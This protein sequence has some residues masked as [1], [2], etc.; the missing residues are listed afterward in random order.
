M[1]GKVN[2]VSR[3]TSPP[4]LI[5]RLRRLD[6]CTVSDACDVLGISGVVASV[7]PIWEGARVCG[8]VVTMQLRAV[9]PDSPPTSKV[10]LGVRAIDQCSAGDVIVV[11]N[12]ARV[13]MGGWGG[14][15]SLAA[16]SCGVGGVVI[17]GACRDVDE[18]RELHFPVFAMASVPRT[19][20]GRVYEESCGEAVNFAGIRVNTGDVVIAD[21]SGVVFIPEVALP[22]LLEEAEL[23]KER[24]EGMAAMLRDG[25]LPRDVLSGRYEQLLDD[26]KRARGGRGV[27]AGPGKVAPGV[28]KR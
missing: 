26:L 16:I 9:D 22:A 27:N 5:E 6:V 11:A 14:L 28:A 23:I 24:E 25:M 2:L 4:D 7:A 1:P 13:G 10:H 17:D 19:A 12:E 21:G 8:R 18:A 15:L 20:R 3:L